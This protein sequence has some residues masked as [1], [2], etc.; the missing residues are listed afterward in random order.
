MYV[1]VVFSGQ[2][3]WTFIIIRDKLSVV[4]LN[5]T[6]GSMSVCNYMY[7]TYTVCIHNVAECPTF[8]EVATLKI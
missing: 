7:Y 4:I 2:F 8:H 1:V 6:K 3:K 5:D